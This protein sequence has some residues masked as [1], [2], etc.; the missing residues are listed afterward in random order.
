ML[1]IGSDCFFGRLTEIDVSDRVTVGNGVLIA[2][3][4]FITDHQHSVA[5]GNQI[6]L[7]G[8][9]NSPIVI[10]DDAWIGTGVTVLP[11]VQIGRGAVIGAGAVVTKDVP[12]YE[13]WAGVPAVK[14]GQRE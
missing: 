2:P 13:I 6:R 7:Q 3:R 4:V 5:K 10:E 14:I 12:P 9:R 11:G 1:C 8:C